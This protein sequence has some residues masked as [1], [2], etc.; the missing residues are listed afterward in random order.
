MDIR[1][2]TKP[3]RLLWA[4]FFSIFAAGVGFGVRGGILVD[5]AHEYGFTQK[6]LGDISGGGLWGFGLVIILGS[7]IADKIGYGR[8]MIVAFVMH[9]LSAALQMC[10]GPIFDNFGRDGVYTSLTIAMVM[11]SVANGTCEVVVNPM[12]AALFPREKTHF[13]NILHAGWPGGLIAGGIVGYVMNDIVKVHWII[14]MSM[15]LI[16]VA[17][18]GV[19]L[20]GQHLPRSEASQ[21]G[22]SF[23]TMLTEFL[24]PVLLLL[25]IIHAMVGYVELGTD[26]WIQKITGSIMDSRGAGVLLFIYTSGLMFTLRFFAGPIEHAISPLGLLLGSAIFAALG[27]TLL[28]NAAGVLFCIGAVTV[29]GI[30]KTFF[31]PTMLAVV[32]ERFPKGGALTL[33]AIGGMGMLSA[34]FLGGPGIGFK[35]DY[36]ATAKLKEIEA[37]TVFT[38]EDVAQKKID[39]ESTKTYDRYAAQQENMFLFF[40]S[41]GLDGAKVGLLS[42]EHD[43]MKQ[44]KKAHKLAKELSTLAAGDA[45]IPDLTDEIKKAEQGVQDAADELAKTLK[46]FRASEDEDQNKLVLWWDTKGQKYANHD[47]KPIDEAGIYGGQMALLLTAFVPATMAVLYLFLILYFKL[48][49]GYQRVELRPSFPQQ[50]LL[51]PR[52]RLASEENIQEPGRFQPG[53]TPQE[54]E[55]RIK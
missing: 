28:G 26:N 31:W 33:G 3:Q 52:P 50:D 6:E 13:L 30:G 21:A 18:Y 15:F 14:Q 45:K 55:D 27:L 36:Y 4:G 42:L 16:P 35:Q 17:I 2:T 47:A 48:T 25:V 44:E 11:F 43:K 51:G 40:T 29:Y 5:W 39:F 22:L 20:A 34:G 10:T 8:L 12:V 41:K 54:P 49:G 19:M 1:T 23:R 32:S 9:V 53:S 38:A 7:L 24:A 37:A 46:K